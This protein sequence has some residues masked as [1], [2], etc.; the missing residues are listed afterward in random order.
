MFAITGATSEIGKALSDQL[1]KRGISY[2]A[3][4]RRPVDGSFQQFALG[5]ECK[6]LEGTRFVVHLAWD[7]GPQASSLNVPGTHE[8]CRTAEHIGAKVILLSS[9]AVAR[10]SSAYALQKLRCEQLVLESGGSVIRAGLVWGNRLSGVLLSLC[11]L[12]HFGVRLK[13]A[14]IQMQHSEVNALANVLIE[15]S[16][17]RQELIGGYSPESLPLS[18]VLQCLHPRTRGIGLRVQ[19]L[20]RFASILTVRSPIFIRPLDALAYLRHEHIDDLPAAITDRENAGNA[21][22]RRFVLLQSCDY[23]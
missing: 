17:T 4:S 23:K 5:D 12:A 2:Y 18:E 11:R 1:M 19:Q 7:R 10:P 9:V 3:L 6:L 21:A 14:D 16:R 22:F 15:S 13:P 8:V 20:S